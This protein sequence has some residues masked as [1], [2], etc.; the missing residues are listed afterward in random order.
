VEIV[1][2]VATRKVILNWNSEVIVLVISFLVKKTLWK[3]DT[4]LFQSVFWAQML[5]APPSLLFSSLFCISS[6]ERKTLLVQ[7]SFVNFGG[8]FFSNEYNQR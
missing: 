3:K 6:E 8:G 5:D 4:F 2:V 1:F 7:A